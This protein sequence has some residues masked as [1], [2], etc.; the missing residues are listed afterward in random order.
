[1]EASRRELASLARIDDGQ[2]TIVAAA[3]EPTAGAMTVVAGDVVA[4]LPLAGLM[5]LD[6]E[7]AR[8]QREIGDAEA[9]RQRAERQLA[10]ESFVAKAP[11]PVVQVQR[12]RL[13]TATEQVAVLERRLAEL[14]A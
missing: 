4:L 12:K 5:D 11:P 8:L 7:R 6:A 14:G 10:N 2:L 13:A 3:T 1:F 9:E